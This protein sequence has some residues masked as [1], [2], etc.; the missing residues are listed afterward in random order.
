MMQAI[1]TPKASVTSLWEMLAISPWY[2]MIF[3]VILPIVL[4]IFCLF[5]TPASVTV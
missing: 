1:D 5:L 2:K 4:G 3:I